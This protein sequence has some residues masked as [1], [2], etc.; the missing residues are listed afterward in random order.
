MA[1]QAAQEP[2]VAVGIPHTTSSVWQGLGTATDMAGVGGQPLCLAAA[3]EVLIDGGICTKVN[4]SLKK[5]SVRK[6]TIS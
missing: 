1:V 3:P 5:L 4:H 6:L 2:C